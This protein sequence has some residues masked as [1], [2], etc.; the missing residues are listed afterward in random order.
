MQ[1]IGRSVAWTQEVLRCL[2]LKTPPSR[3]GKKLNLQRV[4][5]RRQNASRGSIKRGDTLVRREERKEWG[6]GEDIRCVVM[7]CGHGRGGGQVLF[8]NY[9]MQTTFRGTPWWEIQL[10]LL[11]EKYVSWPSVL[12]T[13][14]LSPGGG[15]VV[16]ASPHLIISQYADSAED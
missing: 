13:I 5:G 16:D 7:V 14:I 4:W 9:K 1:F 11:D 15:V 10:R 8:V 6:G 3:R 2:A 12:I